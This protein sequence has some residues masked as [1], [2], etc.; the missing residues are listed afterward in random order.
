M[1]NIS[2]IIHPFYQGN[3]INTSDMA[4]MEINT[5]LS[6]IEQIVDD[7]KITDKYNLF[8]KAQQQVP[9]V[10][11]VISLWHQMKEEKLAQMGLSDNI[12][13]WF[14]E[15]LL[16]KTYWKFAIKRTKHKPT[17][18]KLNREL[19]KIGQANI[20]EPE[21][22]GLSK[23]EIEQLSEAAIDLC[24]KF[25]RASSQVEGRNGYLS[26]INHNQRSFDDTRLKVL[27]VVHN[28][29]IRGLDQKTPAERLF[30]DNL[31]FK[32]LANY[33]IDNFGDLPRSRNRYL[34]G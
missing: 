2:H 5:E 6:N 30:G 1:R 14:R 27:T 16:P 8:S 23:N 11:S 25:Q 34:S 28:F 4:E 10:V 22:E 29:G 13:K 17:R 19:Q 24:R 20:N 32:P 18:N 26:L 31:Q 7:C 15:Y 3:K 9:D 12:G 33:I 21:G